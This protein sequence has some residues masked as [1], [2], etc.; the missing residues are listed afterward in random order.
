MTKIK[1]G[2][3]FHRDERCCHDLHC[4]VCGGHPSSHEAW[5]A[6]NRQFP[7]GNIPNVGKVDDE[8]TGDSA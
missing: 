5:I 7:V 8:L 6:K 3:H 2:V 1:C 4:D